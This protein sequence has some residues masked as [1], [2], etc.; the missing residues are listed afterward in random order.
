MIKNKYNYF[1]NEKLRMINLNNLI[2]GNNIGKL[3][4]FIFTEIV[5]EKN[6]RLK[7]KTAS[8]KNVRIYKTNQQLQNK[9]TKKTKKT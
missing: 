2:F 3:I 1:S 5:V 9:K 6:G 8:M 4:K 7:Q